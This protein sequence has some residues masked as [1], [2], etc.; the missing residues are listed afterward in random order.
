M[1]ARILCLW[2]LVA[3]W[4]WCEGKYAGPVPAKSDLPY[5][6]QAQKL[7]EVEVGKAR[8][9]KK[10][11]GTLVVV[12]GAASPVRTPL[13]EP[14]FLLDARKIAPERVELF[15]LEVKDGNRQVSLPGTQ[16]LHLRVTPLNDHLYKIEPS[17]MLEA[18]EYAL[19]SGADNQVFC[20]QVY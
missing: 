19:R 3:G 1:G 13:P 7:T 2:F 6:L 20:F 12:A 5:L 4:G 11:D 10:K 16:P 8:E 15:L 18:G 9:E 14:I 17:E